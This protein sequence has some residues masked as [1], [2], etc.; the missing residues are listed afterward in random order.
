MKNPKMQL[1]NEY[2]SAACRPCCNVIKNLKQITINLSVDNPHL[3]HHEILFSCVITI[4]T[5]VPI[6]YKASLN[7]IN[8]CVM[9]RMKGQKAN[10]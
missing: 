6:C 1:S 5:H 4:C 9:D 2:Y 7:A 10:S 8:R 3:L